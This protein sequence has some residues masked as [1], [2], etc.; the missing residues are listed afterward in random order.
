MQ[1]DSSRPWKPGKLM[2]G[3][4]RGQGDNAEARLVWEKARKREPSL[5][6]NRPVTEQT[7]RCAHVIDKETKVE[8]HKI[9]SFCLKPLEL[10]VEGSFEAFHLLAHRPC[11]SSQL[12]LA[13]LSTGRPQ[14]LFSPGITIICKSQKNVY[15]IEGKGTCLWNWGGR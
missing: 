12:T 7:S 3:E 2:T 6:S 1:N 14:T 5:D 4:T 8:K 9:I 10:S 11:T 13:S 15:G